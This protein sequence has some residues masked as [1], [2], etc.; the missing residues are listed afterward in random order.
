[1]KVILRQDVANIGK[2]GDTHEVSPG[3]FRNYLQPRGLA[4]EATSGRIKNQQVRISSVSTKEARAKDQTKQ[5]AME[6]G[7]LT[8]TFSVKVGEQGRMYGSVT[9]KDIAEELHKVKQVEV[10]RHKIEIGEPLRSV[11]EHTVRVKLDHG[12]EAKVKVDLVPEEGE[13]G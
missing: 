6:L 7:E 8:L 10:D 5:L 9:A 12:I 2:E 11:G 4:V 3:Y 1:M 13:T